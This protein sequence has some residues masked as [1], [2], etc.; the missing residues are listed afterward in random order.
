MAMKYNV[1]D[2][3]RND[4][5]MCFL[6]IPVSS[7]AAVTKGPVQGRVNCFVRYRSL[8]AGVDEASEDLYVIL[9]VSKTA[10]SEEIKRNYQR[11][12][13]QVRDTHL[14]KSF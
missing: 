12:V 5:S 9:G 13:K 10:S 7:Y 8:M 14:C 4:E 6:F 3:P 2:S 11:L 1:G